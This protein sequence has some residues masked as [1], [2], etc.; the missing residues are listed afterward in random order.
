[1][2]ALNVRDNWNVAKN[3]ILFLGDGMGITAVT[4]ARIYKGQKSGMNGEEGYLAWE[5][6]PNIAL[7]KTYNVD[8]QVPDSAAT[9]TAFLC[10]VKSNFYTMG[11]DSSVKFKHCNTT[12]N[13]NT[14]LSSIAKWAQD[15]G[16]DTGFV[17]TTRVTHATPG[18]LYAHTADRDWESDFMMKE[19]GTGCSD[20]ATQLV[21][22]NPGRNFKVIM[23]GGREVLG[24]P[25]DTNTTSNS[26]LSRLD[27]RNLTQEWL[28]VKLSQG[29]SAQYITTAEHLNKVNPKNTDFLMGLFAD[30]HLPFVV[31]QNADTEV[32]SLKD[33]T[34]KAI[35]ILEKSE[36]GFF[37]LV[38]GGRIDHGLHN[39]TPYY[40]VE[41]TVALDAAVAAAL[42][43]VDL[44]E[45]LVLVTADHSHV[46]T[47]NG[48]PH[49]GND[50]L[51]V[52]NLESDVDGLNYTTLMFTNGPG[53]N[54]TYDGENVTRYDPM[55]YDTRDL[56][57]QNLAAVPRVS[58]TH[59]GE[60]VAIWAA[61]PMA[62][63]LHRTHEQHYVAHVMAHAAGIG[64]SSS[65]RRRPQFDTRVNNPQDITLAETSSNHYPSLTS[66]QVAPAKPN[67]PTINP[68]L[69]QLLD[70]NEQK[71]V[72][73]LGAQ[74][75]TKYLR[76]DFTE[77]FNTHV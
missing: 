61:G 8:K 9:A 35:E 37:L 16:M 10:G 70:D 29:H 30:S 68:A 17:T 52:G 51:G 59:G 75:V 54:Y 66:D 74:N 76:H 1:M 73:E 39:N 13:K 14:H 20:V 42:R 18:A 47:I 72:Q 63:L 71:I 57:Y 77:S 41:E 36:K 44:E 19:D 64:P 26:S 4:A 69:R 45:T 53:F 33:M 43:K 49:R 5:R 15:A 25:L 32:P 65:W 34:L 23:G 11:V 21:T 7:L 22:E 12:R 6:F 56:N 60:D 2:V 67:F 55:N 3:V 24:A 31:E 48:Y 46:M 58:E 40:S 27:G 62:H 28:T 38:E 50:I